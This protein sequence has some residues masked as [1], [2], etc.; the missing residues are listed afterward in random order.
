MVLY[1]YNLREKKIWCVG[2]Q[3]TNGNETK[4]YSDIERA[5]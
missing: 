1:L 5:R 4:L 3:L 2:D